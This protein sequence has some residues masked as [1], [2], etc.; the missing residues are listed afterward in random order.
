MDVT[1]IT[2]ENT[3]GLLINV[4]L[5]LVALGISIWAIFLASRY[6]RE[7]S[8]SE[9][10]EQFSQVFMEIYLDREFYYPEE[11]GKKRTLK[12]CRKRAHNKMK[13]SEDEF[14][15]NTLING[16]WENTFAHQLSFSLNRVGAL[17]LSG[18][19]PL[20]TVLS[21]S[22]L[23]IIE[24]WYFCQKLILQDMRQDDF[25]IYSKIQKD[26]NNKIP[27]SRRHA[28]WLAYACG[29][30][31]YDNWEGGKLNKYLKY[32]GSIEEV[33]KRE[34]QIRQIESPLIPELVKKQI[35]ELLHVDA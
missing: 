9:Q 14:F 31:M 10:M 29:I 13:K 23:S 21:L 33:K 15:T 17:I 20:K 35:R 6:R 12:S 22:A 3:L 1:S 8:L 24:D 19:L 30:W 7:L 26:G 5:P 34:K 28:E 32:L 2:S 25:D 18:A 27:Y 16:K 11:S 4:V